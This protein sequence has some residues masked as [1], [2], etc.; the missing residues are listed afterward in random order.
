MKGCLGCSVGRGKDNFYG[1][2]SVSLFF[3]FFFSFLGGFSRTLKLN[4]PHD[5]LLFYRPKWSSNV[6][7]GSLEA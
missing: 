6:P 5:L 2:N 4:F 7:K 1:F 3:F